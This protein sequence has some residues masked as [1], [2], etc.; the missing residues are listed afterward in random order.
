MGTCKLYT[1][2]ATSVTFNRCKV[3]NGLG[4]K[5]YYQSGKK[6]SKG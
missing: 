6:S 3:N 4:P 2:T 1:A 5:C